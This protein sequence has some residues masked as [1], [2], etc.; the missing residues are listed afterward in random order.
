[1]QNHE[2]ISYMAQYRF[3]WEPYAS[4]ESAVCPGLGMSLIGIKWSKLSGKLFLKGML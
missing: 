4:E 3:G 1:M 2:K